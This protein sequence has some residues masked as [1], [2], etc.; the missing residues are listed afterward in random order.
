MSPLNSTSTRKRGRPPKY[1]S[2]EERQAAKIT[3]QR[4]Q[5]QAAQA[6]KRNTFFDEYYSAGPSA[7]GE[8]P[9]ASLPG[10]AASSVTHELEELLPPLSPNPAPLELEDSSILIDEP[11]LELNS[12]EPAASPTPNLPEQSRPTHSEPL[13]GDLSNLETGSPAPA[14]AEDREDICTLARAL[15]DQL[16]Q[17][18]GCCRECHE[19]ARVAHHETHS[20]H[21]GLGDVGGF[22]S[23]LAVARRGIRWHPTQMAVSDL[24]SSLHIDPVSVQY[25]D[26]TGQAHHISLCICSFPDCTGKIS[27]PARLLDQDFQ[28][29]TDEILLPIINRC[30]SG[31]LIQHYPSSF[32][33]SRLNAT[34][35]GVEMRSQ[36]VDPIPREQ[37]LSYFL[38]PEALP[39]IWEQILEAT[40]RPGFH[41]FQDLKILIEGKNLKTLTKADT[42]ADL[43]TGFQQHWQNAVNEDVL[44]EPFFYDLE[45][46]RTSPQR[47][48][49]LYYSQFY[50]SV[51]EVFAAGNTYP[52]TNTATETLALDPQLRKTWQTVGGGLSHNPI[53]L[54]RAYLTTK[55][56]CHAAL[57]GSV[58]KVFGLREEHRVSHALFCQILHE[59]QTR[60]QSTTRF[61]GSGDRVESYYALP[62][63]T[64]LRWFR[65]NINKFCVGFEMVYSL[66]D[67]HF[68]TWEHTRVML[69]FLRC[70]PFSYSGGLLERVSGCWRDVWFRPDPTQP[71]GLRRCEGLGFQRNMQ[72]FGYGWFLEKIDWEMM[73][74]R[75][76]A[77]QYI[78]F[79]NPSLQAAYH[80][81]Y[82]Q[83]RD[84]RTDFIRISQIHQWMTEFSSIPTCQDYLQKY[85]RQLCLRAFRKDVFTQIKRLLKPESV[86]VALA[87]ETPLCWP[88]LEGALQAQHCP[89]YIASGNRMAVKHINVLFTW[90]WEWRDGRFERKGWD[91]KPYRLL[92]QKSFEVITL[93]QGKDA[94][95]QWKQG[96]KDSF[97]QS[98]WML[99]YPQNNSFMRKSKESGQV[100]WWSS[101]HR[102]MDLYY[103]ELNVFDRPFPA[104]YIKHHPT[105]GWSPSQPSLAHLDYT[106]EPEQRLLHLSD[107]ELY[108]TLRDLQSQ[109]TSLNRPPQRPVH[110]SSRVIFE[111]QE[112]IQ[113]PFDPITG[114]VETWSISACSRKLHPALYKYEILHHRRQCVQ[115]RRHPSSY[116]DYYSDTEPEPPAENDEQTSDE[117]GIEPQKARLIQYIQ[118]IEKR[119]Y[120]LICRDRKQI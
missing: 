40:H 2:A 117:E 82:P 105:T 6:A 1:Q 102:G 41:Q 98:H 20:V 5:R 114:P 10:I 101:V 75:Q 7:T 118:Q 100:M 44:A 115:R 73:V 17:H 70:L 33:H 59:F 53:A 67:R 48:A 11:P 30:Y 92:Y 97:I 8:R 23:S 81:R 16:Y 108:Q 88:S 116:P 109:W 78:Q 119:M 61:L 27:N 99:P 120:E 14:A 83:V 42:L 62:T 69:M 95:R 110:Q 38:P 36:R 46:R 93:I 24:Q 29:W 3:R 32:D 86:T 106:I 18:H 31:D 50:A 47:R 103:H 19:Q 26:S 107:P 80:A 12:L 111:N 74:F 64:L 13:E 39:T 72:Q 87:G 68:V 60:Q 9:I 25:F 112:R 58:P 65:W 4:N 66:N 85:L 89:P 35:R 49:G 76:P 84:V 63:L 55:Q 91:H 22:V 104:S 28:Q 56:R 90:L 52:F 15:A 71:D 94:A 45:T 34:A 21:T 43:M 79:N 37:L 96:L 77:T 54:N 113:N 51:K 57:Q